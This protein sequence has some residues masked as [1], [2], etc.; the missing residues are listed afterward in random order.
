M[1]ERAAYLIDPSF[2]SFSLLSW[3]PFLSPFWESYSFYYGVLDVPIRL[4]NL[5]EMF[6]GD[7]AS[8]MSITTQHAN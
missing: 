7:V 3:A 1:F 2:D 8:S 6:R 5:G 4:Y